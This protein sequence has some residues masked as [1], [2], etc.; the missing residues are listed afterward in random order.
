MTDEAVLE[1]AKDTKKVKPLKK[2][3]VTFHSVGDDKS[4][5]VLVHNY[6][7]NVYQRDKPVEIDENFLAVLRDAK[8]E[9]TRTMRDPATG[10]NVNEVTSRPAIQYSVDVID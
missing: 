1:V 3:K 8:L 2:Y 6:V 10:D 7:A 4:D 9:T 5:V